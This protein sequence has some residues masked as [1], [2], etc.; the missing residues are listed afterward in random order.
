[1]PLLFPDLTCSFFA[2][3]FRQPRRRLTIGGVNGNIDEV[4]LPPKSFSSSSKKKKVKMTFRIGNGSTF[5]RR[6]LSARQKKRN[7]DL[8]VRSV[9]PFYSS[10]AT[11]S[12]ATSALLSR[13]NFRS[14]NFFHFFYLCCTFDRLRCNCS[15]KF[16][17]R[18]TYGDVVGCCCC[19]CLFSFFTSVV[20]P[21]L[22][23]K[24]RRGGRESVAKFAAGV[25]VDVGDDNDVKSDSQETVFS[26]LLLTRHSHS[27]LSSSSAKNECRRC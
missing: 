14:N 20:A 25:D 9:D 3:P 13:R 5:F 10:S 8:N 4:F 6:K 16:G 7:K 22:S 26:L 27:F 24:A 11:A 2:S 1:M 12:N 17:E 21:L 15:A 19:C 18:R 23:S